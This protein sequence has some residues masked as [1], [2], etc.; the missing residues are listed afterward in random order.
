MYQSPAPLILFCDPANTGILSIRFKANTDVQKALAATEQVL[1]VNNPGYPFEYKFI[2]DEFQ[3]QFKTETLTGKLSG[4][5]AALAVF[6]SC[7][8]LFGLAAYAAERRTKEIG[9]R[10]VLGA[11][12][13]VL[14]GLLSKDF[15]A[16]VL[17][18]C[19]IA[20][21]TAWWIM[22]DW[23]NSYAYRT[24]IAWEI[25][26]IA[27]LGALVIALLTVSIITVRAAVV[28]P[29]RSLRSE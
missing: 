5:F 17:L 25:F 11:S 2:S 14:T 23:L 16:L 4:V 8:G 24:A 27:G 29:I 18:S 20:F 6:I 15:L 22:S 21:P 13:P 28:N 10:K 19:I 26:V 12:V 7:L 9:I 3:Q 1:K